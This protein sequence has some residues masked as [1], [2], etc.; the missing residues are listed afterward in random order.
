[1]T[2]IKTKS[3]KYGNKCESSW[4]PRFGTGGA[5]RYHV[6]K[7]TRELKEGN[8]ASDIKKYGTA[9]IAIFDSMNPEYHEAAGRVVDSRKEW[10][11]LDKETGSITFGSREDA[12][13]KV[14][15]ANE[16]KKKKAELRKASKTALDVYRANPKE[17]RQ[18]LEKQGEAQAQ[19]LKKA[20]LTKE[21]KKA[22]VHYE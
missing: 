18:K 4:P 3:F 11:R 19:A 8:P 5:G 1:M 15:Q 17:V 14:D 22:G 16:A 2:E 6:D 10:E 13:P 20:G 21:L 9:P 12:R 7:N